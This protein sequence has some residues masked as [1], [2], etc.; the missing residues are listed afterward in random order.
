MC[1]FCV[2]VFACECECV[3]MCVCNYV[4]L[5]AC[6]IMSCVDFLC[7]VD[8]LLW[9]SPFPAGEGSPRLALCVFIMSKRGHEECEEFEAPDPL[10][11]K[12]LVERLAASSSQFEFEYWPK[13]GTDFKHGLNDSLWHV[14]HSSIFLV[15]FEQP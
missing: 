10:L 6:P 2:Y 12:L 11:G 14:R 8:S 15:R 4:L 5:G 13:K 3:C 1:V 7:V 9:P